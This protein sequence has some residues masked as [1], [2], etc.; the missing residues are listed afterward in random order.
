MLSALSILLLFQLLGEVIVRGLAVPIPGPVLGML[1]LL[2]MLF[3]R[4]GPGQGLQHGSQGLLQHLSLLF[5][6][7]GT[8][9]LLHLH[10]L[11]DE[12]LPIA[13]ALMVSTLLGM[14]VTALTMKAVSALL[15]RWR[16]RHGAAQPVREEP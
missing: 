6:P 4:G 9:V 15:R 14:A 8:G 13:L 5:I 3:V 10:R 12:W 2:L 11:A 16:L 7:A 1:F